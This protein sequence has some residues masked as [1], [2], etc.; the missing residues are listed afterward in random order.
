MVLVRRPQNEGCRMNTWCRLHAD[1][2]HNPKVQRLSDRLYKTWGNLLCLVTTRDGY[3]PPIGD[4]AFALRL[5]EVEASKRVA[6]LMTARFIDDTPNGLRMH[7][8]EEHQ[9]KSDSST[10]R[11]R[12]YRERHKGGDGDGG[13]TSPE[14]HSERSG[15]AT[16]TPPDTEQSRTE[17]ETDSDA[18][19]PAAWKGKIITLTPADYQKWGQSYDRIDLNAEL[20]AADDY[21]AQRPPKDGKWF[22]PVSRWLKKANEE[23][24]AR[25]SPTDGGWNGDL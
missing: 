21:Y 12:R 24:R 20:Q 25:A 15:T 4:V 10:E 8:W 11:T 16:V 3:L 13:E 22:F 14:R 6:E 5:S 7:D 2:L 1:S 23:A 19:G 9:F 17:S 18:E